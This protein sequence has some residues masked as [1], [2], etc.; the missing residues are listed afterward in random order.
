MKAFLAFAHSGF[1]LIALF[2]IFTQS[3]HHMVEGFAKHA[4]FI[5]ASP[6]V[7]GGQGATLPNL[8]DMRGKLGQGGDHGA[9][10]QGKQDEEGQQDW[11]AKWPCCLYA[12]PCFPWR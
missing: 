4:K 2:R 6:H 10:H 9:S 5:I 3:A 12:Q 1:G 8:A 7:K 11:P